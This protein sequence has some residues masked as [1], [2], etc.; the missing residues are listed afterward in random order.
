MGILNKSQLD[1]KRHGL[2]FPFRGPGPSFC[3]NG[4]QDTSDQS[5]DS[6]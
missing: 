3:F 5:A 4:V 2:F 1:R 6:G